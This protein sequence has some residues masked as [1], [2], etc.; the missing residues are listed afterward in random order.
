MAE[1]SSEIMSAFPTCHVTWERLRRRFI[2]R[3]LLLYYMIVD[4]LRCYLTFWYIRLTSDTLDECSSTK[5]YFHKCISGVLLRIYS[6]TG[7]VTELDLFWEYI[8]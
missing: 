4:L 3:A 8:T 6:T 5:K 2:T 1:H 7:Y